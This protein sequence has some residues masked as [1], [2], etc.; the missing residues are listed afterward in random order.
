LEHGDDDVWR[1]KD[2]VFPTVR[3]LSLLAGEEVVGKV[4]DRD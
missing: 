1:P 3:E 2:R 4:I